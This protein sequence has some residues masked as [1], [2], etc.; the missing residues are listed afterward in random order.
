MTFHSSNLKKCLLDKTFCLS[1][2]Q[3]IP[4]YKVDY[5][6]RV[7]PQTM[8][9]S[10]CNI[11]LQNVWSSQSK[12]T[13]PTLEDMLR[14]CV[15][16]F[17]KPVEYALTLIEFSY[18]NS[19]HTTIKVAP[20]E[21]LYG[22]EYRSPIGWTKV[23]DTQLADLRALDFEQIGRNHVEI[24]G[25]TKPEIAFED[26]GRFGRTPSVR[27]NAYS[28]LVRVAR[29]TS[30]SRKAGPT[31]E[32]KIYH[33]LKFAKLRTVS[34]FASASFEVRKASDGCIR[35]CL[36]EPTLSESE[37]RTHTSG[38]LFANLTSVIIFPNLT[39][40]VNFS[41]PDLRTYTFLTRPA[42]LID[43][44]VSA[45][46]PYT[47]GLHIFRISDLVYSLSV[48]Q[49]SIYMIQGCRNFGSPSKY[50]LLRSWYS[51]PKPST[52]RLPQIPRLAN[53]NLG[54]KSKIFLPSERVPSESSNS[55]ST[56]TF[57][58]I[59]T[60]R[61]DLVDTR[62]RSTDV[63]RRIAGLPSQTDATNTLA[64]LAEGRSNLTIKGSEVKAYTTRFT[65]LAILCSV[66]VTPVYKKVERYLWGL[67][68]QIQGMTTASRPDLQNVW[69]SQ[70]KRTIPTLEDMLRTCVIDFWKPV[71]YALTLIEF[72]YNNSFHTTIKVAPFEALYGRE[73]RSPI[74]WTKVDD[75]Q[76]A[77]LR[78]L[79]FEQIGRNHVEIGGETKPEI[80]FEDPGRF[81]RT[82][83]VR[84]NAY[85][86]LVRVARATSPSRKAGPTSELKIYHHL[87]FAKL[88]TVSKFA[89]ASFEVRKASDG[90][91][92]NCLCEP[93]LSESEFRTHTSG[94]LFA[95]LT[96]VIIFPNLTS[97][98]NFSEPD[99]R[100]Y[101][102]LTRPASLIDFVV[103]ALYPYT[104]GLHI[105]RISDLVYSLSVQQLS[106]YMIQGCRNFGSPSKYHLLRSWY[107][108]PK[109]STPRL[110]QIPRLANPNLG[111]KS[112][113]FLPSERVPSES[114]HSESTTTFV[115]ITTTRTDLVDTR[116][117]STDVERRI[118]GLPSQ[119]DATN[120]LAL[121]AEGRSNLTIKGSEVKAYTTRFTPLAILCSV[122]VTPVYKKVERYL[123]GLAPQIQG[124][125]TASRPDLQ[126][127]WSSQS[128]RTI[129]TLE[130]MLR[131]CVIDFWKPVEYALTLIE[132]SYNNSF[133]TT[134]KVAPFEALYGRE[135]RSP[136]GWTKVDDT[137]LADLRALDFEQIGRNH[138]EI[139]GETKPEIAFEDPGRFGRT[140]SVRPN[141]YS[142][143]V[144]VARA[145]SPSRKAGPTS[146]LKIYHHLK[147]AKLRTVSKFASAS[148]EVRKASDGCI[149]NCLCEPTLSE[150]E[151]RTHTSGHLFANLTSVI[152]FP[153]LTSV[154]NFS[155]PDLRTYTFLTRPASLID[156]VVSALYPYTRGL[157]IFRISDLVYS[158]S[159][160][161]LSIYMIQGCRNFG[162]PSKYHLLRS[163]YSFPKPS[164]P[165][166]PQIPRLAN[167]NLGCKSKIFLPSERVPSESSH[168]ESTTTFVSIT[169]TRTDLVD[170]RARSTDVERRIAG[171]PS[172]TDATNTLALLAEGRSN[173]TIKGSEVKAYTTRFTPLAIL[174]SVV[175]TP[176]YK[177]VE[178][179]LWGL[180]PQ[181]QGMTTASRPDL[182]NVWSSQSKRTIPTL[183]DM[184]R[185]CV[186]DFWKP[187]E[188]A[189]TLIEFSYN[190][191][192]HTTIKVAPFE[193]LYGREYRSPIG[194]TKVDDT[195]LADLRALDFEQI[196]RNHVE[197]GGETK[198]EI[199]FEDPGRFGRTPSVRPNAYSALV[200]V[201]RATSPSRKAGPTSELKIYVFDPEL[202]SK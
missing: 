129:P 118:A 128:K 38:H 186:I 34:K 162:S 130:D 188:Y 66:V 131:T 61:T 50:H 19:F 113:I 167:P 71:E 28:A 75:T 39:S 115:S 101:T 147:F 174:C 125:T 120:T 92:R 107:S 141:A 33:H 106:I 110:P 47:R 111:C 88:R 43:F 150:S 46:Y 90:C 22:R 41:E 64:L 57:V 112:K 58:S 100:T 18:N 148:F 62:A 80:A 109:P 84:P 83:S 12:R 96:S 161:Q 69:S 91:I 135:Y 52:P 55:E 193:A 30:P 44:V 136:I 65:P 13:I 202:W 180:A 23:D 78:A 9:Q 54:C 53:P 127:V 146:E 68:P 184:L 29:A 95:N 3:E 168:S 149:R 42:S 59:T 173:L 17:W 123:W 77:D 182:Q 145:T 158:L 153:N 134:I 195:Q 175:V 164:T 97:V 16:D 5:E 72:S 85:S 56:T 32:L 166:L 82:P 140:P 169:T 89:S 24:G 31:S 133:H 196:G 139:G 185:T 2:R 187:V 121:L 157:H 171:L 165:R 8:G 36:C 73:Y 48:Q 190:N 177:K 154:V 94:H 14:T 119:T 181:I 103:S 191:S 114:S 197:I 132:F 179:Y 37:F 126:N 198:P 117:R 105:F 102:F 194:W 10:K 67:A 137:Q 183:E 4:E 176:V 6:H 49:L 60:T 87:K 70:S 26:P 86:A 51:F 200:R 151:F 81:G 199:A 108:F 192:F 178:R 74:G 155:E 142:A 122:V 124:M 15:I 25:E 45:L 201:A 76:L 116:A 63:E 143:L 27:P 21:A 159:V 104:R 93:T 189:L 35:N 98:V 160:Q 99:L 163:W 156:F 170:T 138:V 152:I 40:V 11:D 144:R 7:S 20:F 79:D 1:L 172:Q